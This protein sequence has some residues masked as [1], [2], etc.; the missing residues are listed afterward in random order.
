[1]SDIKL[2]VFNNGLQMIGSVDVKNYDDLSITISKPV[3]LV[4]VP[5]NTPQA[6]EGQM[7]MAFAPFLQ[8][9]EDWEAGVKFSTRDILTVTT[10]VRDL[11]SSYNSL[12][13][14]GLVL[15]PGIH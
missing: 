7:G 10:P 4:M 11:I 9:T 2:V 13:G 14:S 15:P 6:K 3:Q 8:Y 12:H 1:M 5:S